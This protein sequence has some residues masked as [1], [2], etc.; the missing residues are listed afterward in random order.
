MH[1]K[2]AETLDKVAAEIKA[3]QE[4]ARGNQ[5]VRRPR[6]PMIILR[7]PK[8]WTGPKEVDGEKVEG[9]WRAHQVPLG[10][11]QSTQHRT[12][13]EQWMKGSRPEELFDDSGALRPELQS[14]AP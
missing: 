14:L 12:A 9:T 2:M 8:G 10:N 11:M 4:Q 5:S 3:I 13:L 6:W 7:T 1:E